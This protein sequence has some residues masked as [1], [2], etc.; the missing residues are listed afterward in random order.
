MSYILD[1]LKRAESERSRGAVPTIH[2]PP[3]AAGDGDASGP[4]WRRWG[5]ALIATAVVLLGVLAWWSRDP[6]ATWNPAGMAPEVQA[7]KLATP[8][9]L[10]QPEP[11]APVVPEP[12]APLAVASPPAPPERQPSVA[13]A[14]PASAL[15]MATRGGPASAV[16]RPERESPAAIEKARGAVGASAGVPEVGAPEER[17]YTQKELPD[18]IR[19]SLPVLTVGGATYS[20]NPANRMLIVN[21]AL[22]HEGDKLAPEVTLQHI[23]LRSAVLSYR[24]YR[25]VINY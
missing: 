15:A 14:A 1:A 2:A 19:T 10:P 7:P 3:D 8:P 17:V 21:G 18:D 20:E 11:V 23:K 6:S 12:P 9:L 25:Y 22:F 5:A 13:T 24:G 4:G 16:R